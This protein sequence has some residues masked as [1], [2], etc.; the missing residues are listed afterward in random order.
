MIPPQPRACGVV[1]GRRFKAGIDGFLGLRD[2]QIKDAAA[3]M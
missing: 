1:I 2:G 3:Q